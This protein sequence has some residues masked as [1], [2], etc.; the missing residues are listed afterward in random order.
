[1]G[2][3]GSGHGRESVFDARPWIVRM[4]WRLWRKVVLVGLLRQEKWR[5]IVPPREIDQDSMD[6]AIRRGREL[7]EKYGW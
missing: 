7:A 4:S 6:A 3:T 2:E 5:Y 1:M